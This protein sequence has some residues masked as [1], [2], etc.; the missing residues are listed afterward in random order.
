I[1]FK[2]VKEILPYIPFFVLPFTLSLLFTPLVRQLAVR[3]GLVAYPRPDRWHKSPTALLGGTSIYLSVVFSIIYLKLLDRNVL[4]LLA[5]ATLLFIIGLLDDKFHFT[6]YAKLFAQFLA[7][8]FPIFLGMPLELPTSNIFAVP[9][10]L[11]WIIGVTNSFN[12]LDNI[13]GLAAGV[14]AISAFMMFVSSFFTGNSSLA[15]ITLILCG[16]T[17]GFLPYNFNPA[18]IFMGDSGS[19]FLGYCLAV[20]SISGRGRHIPNLITTMLIPVF[21]LSVPIF[22]TLF[23]MIVRKI[24]GKKIFEG[25]KDH[26][27]HRLVMLGIPQKKAVL[28]LYVI[29]LAFGSIALLYSKL[30]LLVIS[31]IA[32]CATVII[33]YL[34]F[35]LFEVTAL[36]DEKKN[37]G[38]FE[39]RM[40]EKTVL[41]SIL[42]HKRRLIELV[43]DFMFICI[44]YYAAYFLR[45]EN[46]L[47]S[48]N[49]VLLKESLVWIILIKLC[50]FFVF[51][52]YRGVWRYISIADFFTIFKVVSLG[53]VFSIL[54]LTFA[55]RFGSY[56]RA[57]FFI[58][59]LILLFLIMGSRFLFR[60]VGE[61]LS[62][63]RTE[64][65]KVLIFGAGDTGEM[66]VREI[67]RNKALNYHAIGFI[68]DNPGKKG[69]SIQGVA[70]LGTRQDI[71]RLI[72]VYD[73]KEVIFAISSFDA[74]DFSEIT[75]ICRGCGVP[76]RKIRG[77][78]DSEEEE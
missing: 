9:L 31:I 67:K 16:A 21:I 10:I 1:D 29:S 73:I 51:G 40:K 14:A 78:L 59:W 74:A 23:V 20:I 28:L 35:F 3:N 56:S 46:E 2:M 32:F 45:F 54:F 33:I 44:A 48:P 11:I 66:V 39:Q 62:G 26:T 4:C 38:K 22:D 24:K 63:M 49:I 34:G 13:D 27:S 57:V 15:V 42:M 5:G 52:L 69:S 61:F 6:P 55:F 43:L 70:V 19:M 8:C 58:D 41:N 30:N 60:L 75:A 18:K 53:S 17:L 47:L 77:I 25:G 50:V 65:K 7:G 68:D 72:G 71:K 12:L 76:V 37:H 64:G 36:G